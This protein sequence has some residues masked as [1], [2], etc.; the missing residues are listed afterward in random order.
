MPG[1][2]TIKLPAGTFKLT[3]AGTGEDAAATGDL[4]INGNL[5]IQGKNIVVDH[6]RRQRPRPG[7]RGPE[8]QGV[9]L[10]A[11]HSKR[12][13]HAGAG[14]YNA[15]GQVTLTSVEVINNLA[16]GLNGAN[17]ANGSGQRDLGTEPVGF[18]RIE[19]PGRRRSGGGRHLQ[20]ERLACPGRQHDRG[21]IR[22]SAAR[23]DVAATGPTRS[24]P[25]ACRPPTWRP[26]TARS[27]IGGTGGAGGQGGAG[28]GGG[29]FNAGG[30][31]HDLSGRR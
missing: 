6:R 23:A 18:R 5:T 31:P 9:V 15:G 20:R 24:V 29:I 16:V 4:D 7:L 12:A 3:I 11:D 14:L 8:R 28:Q 22:R 1:S 10:E 17:G 27:A 30:E 25:T 19:R 26:A 13:Q 2:D 21:A